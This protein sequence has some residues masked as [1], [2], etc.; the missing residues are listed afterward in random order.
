MADA[1]T[2][3]SVSASRAASPRPAAFV[4]GSHP[5]YFTDPLYP[6]GCADLTI[7]RSLAD[8][9][10]RLDWFADQDIAAY[11]AAWVEEV[12]DIG[13]SVMLVRDPDDSLHVQVGCTCDDQAAD[14]HNRMSTLCDNF[15]GICG[16]RDSIVAHLL[17]TE[18]DRP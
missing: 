10:A 1:N 9:I 11:G 8:A 3:R 4:A 13:C 7:G 14:R 16:G 6:Q 15:V 5:L 12:R 17:R 2:A 18:G